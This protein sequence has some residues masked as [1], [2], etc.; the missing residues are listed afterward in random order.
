MIWATRAGVHI[1]RASS[2]WVISR[3]IDP[4]ATFEFVSDVDEVVEVTGRLLTCAGSS[5]VTMEMT[6]RSKRFCESTI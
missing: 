4:D 1:D 3:F 5:T 6:A 2:A